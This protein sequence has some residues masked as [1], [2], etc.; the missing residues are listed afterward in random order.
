MADSLP[1]PT[2][3]KLPEDVHLLARLRDQLDDYLSTLERNTDS[4]NGWLAENQND[5]IVR[6]HQLVR[7]ITHDKDEAKADT[8]LKNLGDMTG[9][10]LNLQ[11]FEKLAADQFGKDSKIAKAIAKAPRGFP[12]KILED[13]PEIS[14]PQDG[15]D[16]APAAIVPVANTQP[17]EEEQPKKGFWSSVGGWFKGK[18]PEEEARE[19]EAAV[20]R[21]WRNVRSELVSLQSDRHYYIDSF[22]DWIGENLAPENP[23]ASA[24]PLMQQYQDPQYVINLAQADYAEVNEGKTRRLADQSLDYSRIA[25]TFDEQ[26]IGE[27]IQMLPTLFPKTETPESKQ[28]KTLLLTDYGVASFAELALTH[29]KDRKDE[30]A[31]LSAALTHETKFEI[32]GLKSGAQI[33][34]RVLGHVLDTK[35]L[36]SSALQLTIEKLKKQEKDPAALL[37]LSHANKTVFKRI[38]K[39]FGTDYAA[40]SKA[41]DHV[42]K[43]LTGQQS[44]IQ[45]VTDVVKAAAAKDVQTLAAT[46]GKVQARSG[47]AFMAM[48]HLTYPEKSIVKTLT[49]GVKTRKEL[50]WVMENALKAGILDELKGASNA[51]TG[52]TQNIVNFI[53]KTIAPSLAT[54]DSFSRDTARQL[55]AFGFANGGL[56]QMRREMTKKDGWLETIVTSP[57][58]ST[59][60]KLQWTAALLEP[61][62]SDVIK[63]N[64]LNDAA[65]K[66]ADKDAA[67]ALGD[68]EKTFTGGNIRLGD[69]KILTNLDRIANVWYNP[70]PQTLRFT[71]NGTGHTLMEGIS[72]AL[73]RETLEL[74]QRKGTFE[75]EYDGLFN[76]DNIDRVVSTAQGPKVSW[77]R[78]TAD[79]NVTEAQL[80]ALHKRT[81][82]LHED[83]P[84]TGNTFSINQNSVTLL[85]PLEDGTHLLVDKYGTALILDGK[86]RLEAQKPLLDLGGVYFN[87]ENA[88]IVSLSAD[89]SSIE[90]RCENKEFDDF[91]DKAAPGEYFYNVPLPSAA[92][93]KTVEKALKA[94][95]ATQTPGDTLDNLYFNLSALGFMMY[96]TEGETGFHCRKYGPVRKQG[97]IN[98]EADLAKAVFEGLV[99]DDK[100]FTIENVITHKDAIDDAYYN[101]DK[102]LF[103]LVIGQ[104][105][106]SVPC[107]EDTAYDAL[108]KLSKESGFEV[109]GAN[110]IENPKKPGVGVVEMPA[111]VVNLNRATLLAFN[112]AQKETMVTADTDKFPISLDRAQAQTLFDTLESDGQA[113]A[114]QKSKANGWT[115]GLKDSFIRLPRIDVKIAPSITELSPAYLLKQ[116]S[117]ETAETR[118]MPKLDTDFAIAAAALKANDKFTYPV[119]RTRAPITAKRNKPG[120]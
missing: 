50:S 87:P 118:S 79:L 16:V 31:L 111:D 14:V 103:Y 4:I 61:F 107:D 120:M 94:Q 19:K 64:I 49:D 119:S 24:A 104:D 5:I 45:S 109:V 96:E 75:S 25:R 42:A 46:L 47:H 28:L 91:L 93:V 114:K 2:P 41:T 67:Q 97:F 43:G 68:M 101:A 8:A 115:H 76:T 27:F 81:D 99:K 72:P 29:V 15:A 13:L 70:E 86:I 35:P 38:E 59:T 116:A 9:F 54:E 88:S 108:K 78:H 95:T 22:M 33:F 69:D 77:H 113:A 92:D 66:A 21:H 20:R 11:D 7:A 39:R 83:D 56:D 84:K 112:A 44:P 89:K 37:D 26:R 74:L 17:E 51:A 102:A 65:T 18:D 30:L 55:I 52:S 82:F 100:L 98:T 48:W 80:A 63:A 110:Y 73:A 85:Q 71:V 34:E 32:A 105:I 23:E 3:F 6:H 1:S 58:L 40:V 12:A 36:D 10:V 90:F 60:D 53:D 62:A 57:V 117:G 106:L